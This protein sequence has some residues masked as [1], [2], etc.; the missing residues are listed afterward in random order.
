MTRL[1]KPVKREAATGSHGGKKYNPEAYFLEQCG[2]RIAANGQWL[3]QGWYFTADEAM[4]VQVALDGGVL[5]Y[6]PLKRDATPIMQHKIRAI[7]EA[8]RKPEPAAD[9][10]VADA[11]P[12]NN[13]PEKRG[14][15]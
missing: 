9:T 11:A 15:E 3:K 14:P 8:C 7:T 2:W 13:L 1:T 4:T 10:A 12:N 5:K 6:L